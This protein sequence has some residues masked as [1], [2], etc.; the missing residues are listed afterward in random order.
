MPETI[1]S[2]GTDLEHRACLPNHRLLLIS[3]PAEAG[4]SRALRFK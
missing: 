3:P 1:G 2:K 4:S